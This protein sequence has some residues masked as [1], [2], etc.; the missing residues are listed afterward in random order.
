MII[1]SDFKD[2]YDYAQQ[3]GFDPKVVYDRK[4]ETYDFQKPLYHSKF[5]SNQEIH[6][7]LI[8]IKKLM[9]NQSTWSVN[10]WCLSAYHITE[11][12]FFCGKIYILEKEKKENQNMTEKWLSLE[13]YKEML[14]KIKHYR[15]YFIR[16][17]EFPTDKEILEIHEFFDSPVIF[18]DEWTAITNPKLSDLKFY[19]DGYT[20]FSEIFQFLTCKPPEMVHIDD[21]FKVLAHGM[22]NSSFKRDKGGPTRKR[23]KNEKR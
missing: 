9:I 23:K 3:Y 11:P 17:L 22:D 4:K 13:E 15:S 19:L 18:L 6:K 1:N 2:F 8:N 16:N 5:H 20:V 12:L 14:P 10:N 21:K 7:K